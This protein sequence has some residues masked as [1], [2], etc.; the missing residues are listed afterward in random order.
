MSLNA[1]LACNQRTVVDNTLVGCLLL[2]A[3]AEG[4][5]DE[6]SFSDSG[7]EGGSIASQD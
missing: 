2:A 7:M 5:V 6:F 4:M 1:A 3:V